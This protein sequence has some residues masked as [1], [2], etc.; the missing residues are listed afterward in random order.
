M[1]SFIQDKLVRIYFP[2]FDKFTM[3]TNW[4]GKIVKVFHASGEQLSENDQE[5]L[6]STRETILLQLTDK[7]SILNLVNDVNKIQVAI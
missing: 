7:L 3:Q 4:Q 5:M 1:K 6:I 2:Q